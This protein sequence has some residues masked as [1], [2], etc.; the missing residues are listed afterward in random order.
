MSPCHHAFMTSKMQTR[1]E[2]KGHGVESPRCTA[3]TAAIPRQ[4]DESRPDRVFLRACRPVAAAKAAG[5]PARL[6]DRDTRL[7]LTGPRARECTRRY[8]RRSRRNK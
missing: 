8:L 3:A 1:E 6:P 7:P 5:G 2:G 4:G